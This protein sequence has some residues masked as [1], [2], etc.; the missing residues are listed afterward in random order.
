MSMRI[1]EIFTSVQV[2]GA[3]FLLSQ[4]DWESLEIPDTRSKI[5]ASDLCDGFRFRRDKVGCRLS[6]G[7]ASG[8]SVA[9][10]IWKRVP[11]GEW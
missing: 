1:A 2:I 7:D 8:R 11:S 3:T 6:D 4:W 5:P 10:K 9:E